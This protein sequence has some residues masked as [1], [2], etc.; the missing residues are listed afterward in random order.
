MPG[1]ELA[2]RVEKLLAAPILT[3]RRERKG[4][5]ADDDVRP[6][7]L[8]LSTDRL[9]MVTCRP[10]WPRTRVASGPATS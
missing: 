6:A 5:P 10:N 3:V 8:A 2:E 9:P 1:E 4:R 7:I